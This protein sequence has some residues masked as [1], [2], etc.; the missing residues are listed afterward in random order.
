MPMPE[1]ASAPDFGKA[2][3]PPKTYAAAATSQ[4]RSVPRLKP[5][6]LAH[7]P[8]T[9][10]DNIPGIIFT[11][12]EEEQLC[13]SRENTLIMKFSSGKPRLAE[14]RAHIAATWELARQPAVG[15]L[16][17]R[18]VTLNMASAEDTKRALSRP[19][20]KINTSLFR[21]FRWTPDFE[22][23]KE[24]S[25]VAV[26]VKLYNLP[27]HY[28]NEAALQR[29]GSIIGPV[30]RV[31]TH[32]LDLTH[33]IYARVCIEIDVRHESIDKLWIGTSK[34]HGWVI[35]VEYEG[36]H[37]YCSYCGLLGHTVGLCRKKRQ[38]Q[39]KAPMDTTS[40]EPMVEKPRNQINKEHGQW[41]VKDNKANHHK[42][43]QSLQHAPTEILKRPESGIHED[44]RQALK[45]V[46]LLSESEN[47]LQ[48]PETTTT[49]VPEGRDKHEGIHRDNSS[50]QPSQ[51]Q[52]HVVMIDLEQHPVTDPNNGT[53]QGVSDTRPEAG[54]ITTPTKYRF[55]VLDTE[56]ELHNAYHNLQRTDHSHQLALVAIPEDHEKSFSDGSGTR[57]KSIMGLLKPRSEPTSDEDDEGFQNI[58][59]NTLALKKQRKRSST[60]PRGNAAKSSQC[61]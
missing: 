13:R 30:L 59:S 60:E 50:P 10:V 12:V 33:Q 54:L 48:S 29:L 47:E 6:P 20:N 55:D 21:L 11:P 4:P 42:T 32:T 18:H 5:V 37:A 24:S 35:E 25:V 17:P 43:D 7:R 2:Q 19:T 22:I 51:E 58:N 56:G 53:T 15:Y 8:I 38:V 31:D 26:W 34:E 45:N 28:Y 40:K 49:E 27:L 46:G 52:Q 39:G 16:D 36:N 61:Q 57:S 1:L 41:I 23:G 9:Y 14:I 44:T 3:H